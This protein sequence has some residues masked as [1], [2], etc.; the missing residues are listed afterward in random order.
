[1]VPMRTSCWRFL[2]GLLLAVGLSAQAERYELGVR[3]RAF[4]RHLDAVTDET[5][6]AAAY[7]ELER[8]VQ[9]FFRLDTAAVAKAIDAADCALA[10]KPWS[11][12]KR[13]ASSL[14]LVLSQRLVSA[15]AG[16]L[17][18]KLCVAYKLDDVAD[19]DDFD[20]ENC[21]LRLQFAGMQSPLVVALDDVP[22]EIVIPLADAAAGDHWLQWSIVRGDEVLVTR[23][24]GLSV[25]V[26]VAPR[27]ARLVAAAE[28]AETV[29]PETIESKTLPALVKMLQGMQRRRSSETVLPGAQML[30]EAEQ[31]A[32]WLAK[33]SDLPFYGG[34]RP[35]S[36][37]LRVPLGK[38][39]AAVRLHVPKADAP[40]PLVVALHGAGGSE[41]L[42]FDGYGDGRVVQLGAERNWFVV[43]PRL[44]LGP[45]L[46]DQLVDAL[47]ERFPIDTQR[48][49]MVG[50]SMGAMQAVA[51]AMRDPERYRAVAALGGGGQVRASDAVQ[52]LP[53]FVGV[54]SKD[55]ALSGANGLHRALRRAQVASTFR[56]YAQ[57]E[58]LAIVQI[59]LP[60]VFRFFDEVLARPSK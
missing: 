34:H 2:A 5:R 55:F 48:V 50:H 11:A 54:G 14:Q 29:I 4:E 20:L 6:R 58:H 8:A 25:A 27:L 41:N 12:A 38:S 32:A 52:R 28:Q 16:E 30:A 22:Q 53:F 51:N 39:T 7:G 26:D 57:V 33:P 19:D 10:G 36:F 49:V 46:A 40:A 43:A 21:S 24:Q 15:G 42:F 17:T 37:A 59:A 9:A 47:A 56:E 13:Y 60:D 44:S 23:Q 3:L 45:L 35:G 18:G 31:L 1:M